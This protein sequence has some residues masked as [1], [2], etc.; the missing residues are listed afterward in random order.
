MRREILFPKK[1]R[2]QTEGGAGE[3][4]GEFAAVL[5][6]NPQS[7]G[8]G[9]NGVDEADVANFRRQPA[10]ARRGH[11]RNL[12][13]LAQ[14]NAIAVLR[15]QQRGGAGGPLAVGGLR[16]AH[17]AVQA[18]YRKLHHRPADE[19]KT[20]SLRRHHAAENLAVAQVNLAARGA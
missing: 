13:R 14:G 5:Q 17:Q 2:G 8:F 10:P 11:Q 19:N 7:V 20:Q 18:V 3:K 16:A 1:H 4:G 6:G 9:V 12:V 15:L